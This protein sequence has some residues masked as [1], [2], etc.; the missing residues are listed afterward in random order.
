VLEI[1]TPNTDLNWCSSAL[2]VK[3]QDEAW[4]HQMFKHEEGSLSWET[5][6]S[7]PFP[8]YP[9]PPLVLF[10]HLPQKTPLSQ[11]KDR[12]SAII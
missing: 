8:Q 11:D 1:V 3:V 6:R 5:P 9:T 12:V 4:P 10:C 7:A 2:D